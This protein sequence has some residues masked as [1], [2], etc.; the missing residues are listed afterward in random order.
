MATSVCLVLVPHVRNHIANDL[1]R[2]SK[3]PM[4]S[5]IFASSSSTSAPAAAVVQQQSIRILRRPGSSS[6]SASQNASADDG[7]RGYESF[8]D[9]QA[10]YDA[11]RT[12]I[13]GNEPLN[14]PSNIV[15]PSSLKESYRAEERGGFRTLQ[16]ANETSELAVSSLSYLDF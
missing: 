7:S 15:S 2:E 3:P 8:R 13:F 14:K 6:P 16:S 10:A 12:R 9:R 5:I 1:L 11:A 4:P